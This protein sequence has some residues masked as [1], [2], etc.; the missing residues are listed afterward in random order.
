MA[1]TTTDNILYY[2]DNLDIMRERIQVLPV[3]D[4]LHGAD[5]KMSPTH[6]TVKQAQKARQSLG[7]ALH[8]LPALHAPCTVGRG[9]NTPFGY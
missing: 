5:V 6:G 9:Q 8:G 2:G 1:T 4:V 3:A 7:V